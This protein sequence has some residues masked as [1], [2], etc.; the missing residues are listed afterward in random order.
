M[1]D[2]FMEIDDKKRERKFCLKLTSGSSFF[3]NLLSCQIEIFAVVHIERKVRRELE[4]SQEVSLISRK[5][6]ET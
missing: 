4:D 2:F 3:K 6:R 5:A 1:I